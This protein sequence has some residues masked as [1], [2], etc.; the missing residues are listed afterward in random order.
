[1]TE[2][3]EV[4]RAAV[5]SAAQGNTKSRK[6]RK[7]EKKSEMCIRGEVENDDE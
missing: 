2:R 1:M 4:G 5:T 7:R 3:N 6:T